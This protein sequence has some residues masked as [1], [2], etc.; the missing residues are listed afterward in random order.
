MADYI[1]SYYQQIKDGSITA[2]QLVIKAYAYVV[3]GLERK[4][5]VYKPKKANEAISWIQK[6][7]YHTE[8]DMAMKRLKLDLWQKAALAVIFGIY[9]KKGNRQFREIFMVM[10]RKNGKTALGAAIARYIWKNGGFGTRI[11]NLAPKLDQ[12]SLLYD[13][14]WNMTLIDPDYIQRKGEI[15]AIRN[16]SH[17]KV[18]D[19]MLEKHRQ[20]DLYIAGLNSLVI[21]VQS[22][23]STSCAHT[24]ICGNHYG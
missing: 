21:N 12:A 2:G 22:R 17:G 4:D 15:E 20:T 1:L 16:Q 18:D 5:F 8:G 10:G 9:D 13:A 23:K 6:N 3:H 7:C 11:Y 14:I 19:S 24:M